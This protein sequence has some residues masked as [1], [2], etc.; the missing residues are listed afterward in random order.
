MSESLIIDNYFT[1]ICI[2]GKAGRLI[3]R[4]IDPGFTHLKGGNLLPEG[5]ES[6]NC[7]QS[8]SCLGAALQ[9]RR[10]CESSCSGLQLHSDEQFLTQS[11][12]LY[13]SL[14]REAGTA[15]REGCCE[16]A[17]SGDYRVCPTQLLPGPPLLTPLKSQP[18]SYLAPLPARC[19]PVRPGRRPGTVR[20]GCPGGPERWPLRPHRLR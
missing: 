10:L 19:V 12:G 7:F 3:Q 2:I 13:P 8:W 11:L 18:R 17:G 1:G 6:V 16:A 5:R 4:G 14:R 20:A 9:P 15:H